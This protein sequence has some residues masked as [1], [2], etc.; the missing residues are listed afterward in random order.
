MSKA[1][2]I[3]GKQMQED[4]LERLDMIIEESQSYYEIAKKDWETNPIH[5]EWKKKYG[6]GEP[7]GIST[8]EWYA[9]TFRDFK[10]I[11]LALPVVETIVI[12]E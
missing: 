2:L 4:I 1:Y 5:D 10:E 6:D 3:S 12:K 8:F 9:D 11:L 7:D